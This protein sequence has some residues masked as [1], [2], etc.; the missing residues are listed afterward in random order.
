MQQPTTNNNLD[1]DNEELQQHNDST[2]RSNA[3]D[4]EDAHDEQEDHLTSKQIR[5]VRWNY[6]DG[7][8]KLKS[9]YAVIAKRGIGS[10]FLNA[11]NIA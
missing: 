5:N 1:N 10:Q 2:S 8:T 3:G 6:L 7:T 4:R 9:Q 11:H